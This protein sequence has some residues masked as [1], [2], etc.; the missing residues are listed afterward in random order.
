MS[1][2]TAL[3]IRTQYGQCLETH[4][5]LLFAAVQA[6]HC[7]FAWMNSYNGADLAWLTR[8]LRDG[9]PISSIF[10]NEKISLPNLVTNGFLSSLQISDKLKE[11][12]I[13]GHYVEWFRFCCDVFVDASWRSEYNA[14][15]HG[16]RLSSGGFSLSIGFE[17]IP[18]VPAPPER[19]R[20]VMS[21]K[22]GSSTVRLERASA[23]VSV[24]VT[25]TIGWDLETLV[26]GIRLMRMS[27]DNIRSYARILNGVPADKVQFVWPDVLETFD[28]AMRRTAPRTAFRNS[29]PHD[30]IPVLDA[31]QLRSLY[32]AYWIDEE[33]ADL[34]PL[35]P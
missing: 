13:K 3:A 18:G 19:M 27:M 34:E 22:F 5:A 9:V 20:S 7:V 16:L 15:K 26:A 10:G 31:D 35:Q 24:A 25:E 33:R 32:E 14:A 29:F 12:A 11:A 28:G 2:S 6:P 8:S 23:N 1:H 17:D 21:S 4:Q 30:Q